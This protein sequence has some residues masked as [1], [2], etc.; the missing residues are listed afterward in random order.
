MNRKEFLA[1]CGKK[2]LA[3]VAVSMF[4]WLEACSDKAQQEVKGE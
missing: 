2:G 4:P 3:G 1:D